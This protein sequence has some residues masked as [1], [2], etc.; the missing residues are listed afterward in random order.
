[1][2]LLFIEYAKITSLDNLVNKSPPRKNSSIK[3][4]FPSVWKAEK[5][6]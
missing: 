6:I 5:Y 3:Y 1:M 4:N 2:G